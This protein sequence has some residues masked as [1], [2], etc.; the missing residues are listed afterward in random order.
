MAGGIFI[1]LGAFFADI[2][3]I[4]RVCAH[5][6]HLNVRGGE[7]VLQGLKHYAIKKDKIQMSVIRAFLTLLIAHTPIF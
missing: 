2:S 1:V 3:V 4:L 5:L 7:F 6:G